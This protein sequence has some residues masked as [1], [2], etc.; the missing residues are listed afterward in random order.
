M[1]ATERIHALVNAVKGFTF[2]D[3]ERVRE[4]VN[5]ARGLADT[6]AMLE[7]KSR[8]KP[9]RVQVETAEDLPGVFGFG[10]ELNQVWEKLIDNAIDAARWRGTYR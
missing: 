5:I 1:A 6:V 7:N 3:R 4:E 10:S 8:S 2:M 9:V